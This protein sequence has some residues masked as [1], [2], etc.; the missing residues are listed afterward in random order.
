[1]WRR[2]KKENQREE[3]EKKIGVE[4]GRKKPQVKESGQPLETGN[5]QGNG[6]FSDLERNSALPTS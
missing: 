4:D 1:M 3:S 6:F 2:Q 5:G